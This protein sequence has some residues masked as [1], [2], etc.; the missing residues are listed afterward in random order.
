MRW[1]LIYDSHR[2]GSLDL[3]SHVWVDLGCVLSQ[4]GQIENWPKGGPNGL[5]LAKSV[6]LLHTTSV[7]IFVDLDDYCNYIVF[8]I[9]VSTLICLLRV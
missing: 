2:D 4:M 6:F 8:V 9:I 5:K 1:H 7:I 3:F